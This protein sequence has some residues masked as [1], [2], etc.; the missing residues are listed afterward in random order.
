M[1]SIFV[2]DDY[3]RHMSVNTQTGLWRCFKT[4][5]SGNFFSLYAIT[6]GLTYFKAQTKVL[7]ENFNNFSMDCLE[8]L[9]VLPRN[10]VFNSVRLNDL[11]EV[12]P[13]SDQSKYDSLRAAHAYLKGRGIVG[14]LLDRFTF[15]VSN[16]TESPIY[17]RLVIPFIKDNLFYFYQARALF[18]EVPKYLTPPS[19]DGVK[20]SDIL[21]PFDET[22][23]YLIITEGPFDAISLSIHDLNATCTMG[24]SPSLQQGEII[25]QFKGNVILAYDNDRAGQEGVVKFEKLRKKLMFPNFYVAN[26]PVGC[27]DWS[28]AHSR[29][30]DL[31]TEI[32]RAVIADEYYFMNLELN[33]V[34]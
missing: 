4:E 9:K 22:K 16:D 32:R 10:P 28:D 33:Q 29:G 19:A 3:K 34:K 7:L 24:S 1:E 2:P 21:Y 31:K 14:A 17:N 5:R 30:F 11:Q 25:K 20:G 15:Y 12:L 26:P 23:D 27:K 6:E 13:N 8:P 18:N